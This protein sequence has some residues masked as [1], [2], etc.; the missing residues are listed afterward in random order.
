MPMAAAQCP[1]CEKSIHIPDETEET[2]CAYCGSKLQTK[3]AIELYGRAGDVPEPNDSLLLAELRS[4]RE[5][6]LSEFL[7]PSG[8]GLANQGRG[9]PMQ[10]NAQIE[11]LDPADVLS[12]ELRIC[13]E[14]LKM[15]REACS[16]SGV[17]APGGFRFIGS[18]FI[19]SVQYEAAVI[20]H[21]DKINIAARQL[22]SINPGY[23]FS[24]PLDLLSK[25]VRLDKT[26]ELY[27]LFAGGLTMAY[28]ALTNY[29]IP[30]V[31]K[32]L[33]A[34]LGDKLAESLAGIADMIVSRTDPQELQKVQKIKIRYL[35]ELK[36]LK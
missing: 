21:M 16:P 15:L 27:C 12:K 35:D 3:A 33:I 10:Y 5:N 24:A 11:E 26:P 9:L 30:A 31:R 20:E 19:V 17:F 2:F 29:F 18:K 1:Y 32:K 4:L 36:L 8:P 7:N 34:P 28:L 13:N 14:V 23:D 6:E 25:V 22:L